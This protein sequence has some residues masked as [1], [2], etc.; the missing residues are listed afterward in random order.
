[1]HGSDSAKN[2]PHR[3]SKYGRKHTSIR[4]DAELWDWFVAWCGRNHESTCGILEPFLYALQMT[5][6]ELKKRQLF[7][8]QTPLP[9]IDL[10][11]NVT[12]EVERHRRREQSYGPVWNDWGDHL[13]CYFCGELKHLGKIMRRHEP[14]WVVYYSPGFDRSFRIWTCGYHVRRY[15]RII[16]DAAGYP[17]LVIR[18]I[19]K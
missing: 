8:L 13:H 6:G 1:M 18:P 17:Q 16:G 15:H 2:V 5:D 11:L 10:T 4:I 19:Y 14:R 3:I 12:R 7:G 9:K